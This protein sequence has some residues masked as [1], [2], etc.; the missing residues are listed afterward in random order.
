MNQ[1]KS[2]KSKDLVLLQTGK[3]VLKSNKGNSY[4]ELFD[5]NNQ[6]VMRLFSEL[7]PKRLPEETLDEAAYR[8]KII[9][10]YD[11]QRKRENGTPY[12]VSA[13]YVTPAIHDMLKKGAKTE[14]A[15]KTVPPV[16][17]VFSVNT[18]YVKPKDGIPTWFKE[19]Q[20]LANKATPEQLESVFGAGIIQTTDVAREDEA[21][22]TDEHVAALEKESNNETL[23][24]E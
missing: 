6:Y 11:K 14:E 17:T 13:I 1:K 21:T 10:M 9:N 8:R 2:T 23:N 20:E 16:G 5:K 3:E 24:N 12:Y 18:P 4:V 19:I 15:M 7:N 22:S